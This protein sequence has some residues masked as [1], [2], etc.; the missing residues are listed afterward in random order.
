MMNKRGAVA[1]YRKSVLSKKV[2]PKKFNRQA[3]YMEPKA[4]MIIEDDVIKGKPPKPVRSKEVRYTIPNV[5][6]N[7]NIATQ[8]YIRSH[9]VMAVIMN[10]LKT[11]VKINSFNMDMEHEIEV[12]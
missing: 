8:T 6:N 1:Q 4:P 2:A 9:A 12:L 3:V 10:E 5:P 7:V 11:A